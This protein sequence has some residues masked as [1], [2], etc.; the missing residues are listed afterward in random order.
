MM[1]PAK[2][3]WFTKCVIAICF[4]ICQD[5]IAN[6][7]KHCSPASCGDLHDIRYPF[8]L[9]TSSYLSCLNS[10]A[11]LSCQQNRTTLNLCNG[12]YYVTAINYQHHTIQV[13]DPGLLNDCPF[14]P[15]NSLTTSKFYECTYPYSPL[16]GY[17]FVLSFLDCSLPVQSPDYIQINCNSSTNSSY[18]YIMMGDGVDNL[19]SFCTPTNIIPTMLEETGDG[20]SFSF[21][22]DQLKTG[23]ELSWEGLLPSD[24]CYSQYQSLHCEYVLISLCDWDILQV[25]FSV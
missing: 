18:S 25:N 3:V 14:K 9:N 6:G 5:A 20:L 2:S 16:P 12:T 7:E 13:V 10:P 8:R 23:L 17:D 24:F 11:E 19:H 22:R 4:A 15:L 1:M 21:I